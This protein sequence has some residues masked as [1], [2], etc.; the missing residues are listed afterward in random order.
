MS[1]LDPQRVPTES[2]RAF[3]PSWRPGAV[4]DS[5][6]EFLD[7]VTTG[8]GAVPVERRIAA[9]DNDGTVACEKPHTVLE[10]FLAERTAGSAA[11]PRG[12]LGA[13]KSFVP[14]LRKGPEQTLASLMA[15]RTVQEYQ[16]A[17]LDFL[18][19]ARHPRFARPWQ[20]LGYAPMIELITVLKRLGFTVYLVSGGSRDLLRTFALPAYGLTRE[21]VIG[22]EVTVEYRN[23]RLVRQDR[24]IPRDRGPGK[25]AH[26]WDRSGGVPLFAAGNSSGDLELLESATFGLM[27]SHDD[28]RRECAY[29]DPEALAA[30]ATRGWTVASMQADF[31]EIFSPRLVAL[32]Q[33]D[34]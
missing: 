9:F 12:L 22:T 23:G 21:H 31:A 27:V 2:A 6:V 19:R 26:L 14:G 20:D 24:L 25:P 13:A 34:V 10:A 29:D 7:S 5:I 1:D 4:K 18:I 15:G 11:R 3:L 16:A 30:A 8:P 33:A 28:R 32:P 17:V